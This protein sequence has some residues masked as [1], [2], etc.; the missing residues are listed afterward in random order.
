MGQLEDFSL[1]QLSIFVV[2]ILGACGG[3]CAIMIKSKCSEIQMGCCKI[4][5]NPEAITDP[6]IKARLEKEKLD[7]EKQ[8]LTQQE[9]SPSQV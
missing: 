9:P 3:L 6:E 2:A 8:S 5:R 7:N 4:K 1:E